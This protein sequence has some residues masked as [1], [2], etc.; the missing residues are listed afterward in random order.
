MA[1]RNHASKRTSSEW[2][3]WAN[4][5]G[6]IDIVE[7][8]PNAETHP[9]LHPMP[10]CVAD[11]FFPIGRVYCSLCATSIAASCSALKQHCTGY[12]YG[13]GDAKK[14]FETAH[15]KKVKQRDEKA[16][17]TPPPVPPQPVPPI[18]IQVESL[19]ICAHLHGMRSSS[20]ANSCKTGTQ[21]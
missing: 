12:W 16:A 8:A 11:M 10:Y 3:T 15:A 19:L 21:P 6:F 2:V 13:K 9:G 5:E 4:G 17:A 14:F 18:V 7:H 1:S 20:G